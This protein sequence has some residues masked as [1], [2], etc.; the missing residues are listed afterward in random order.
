VISVVLPFRNAQKT[1]KDAVVS[2]FS[3]SCQDWELLLMD[4]C[5]SDKSVEIAESVRDTRVRV[6][7]DGVHRG[8]SAQLNRAVAMAHGKYVARMDADDIAYPD[9]LQK[10]FEFLES[11]P[12][13][14]LV[15]GWMAIFR[16]DGTLMGMRRPPASHAEICARPWAGIPIGHPTWMGRLEWFRRSPYRTDAIRMED[17]ELLLRTHSSSRFANLPEVV[18]GYREDSL[19]LGKLLQARK[20]ICKL[21][22]RYAKEH[23]RYHVAGMVIAG[24]AARSLQ[25]ILALSTGLGH[26]LLRHRAMPATPAEAQ[27]WK[28]VWEEISAANA[29]AVAAVADS[30][31]DQAGHYQR[32]QAPGGEV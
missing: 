9:R 21:A 27:E 22:A 7:A 15:G 28:K 12:E 16:S 25:D 32:S 18:L 20:N 11:H 23:K 3:Q 14:D 24:Q 4:D 5:S 17:W 1:L 31:A 8:L 26:K 29:D 30:A 13:V 10:Q 6:V 2:I 19:S